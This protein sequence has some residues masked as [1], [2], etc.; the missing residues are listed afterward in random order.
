MGDDYL[1]VFRQLRVSQDKYIYTLLAAAG[2]AVALALN[3]TA[4]DALAIK[5]LP[6]A[7]ALIFWGLSFLCGVRNLQ[8][9][10]SSLYANADFLRVIR[11]EHPSVGNDPVGIQVASAGIRDAME[12]NSSKA[13][14]Y[15]KLQFRFFLIGAASYV[16]WHVLLMYLRRG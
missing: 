14:S 5:H 13:N 4:T 12:S 7:L 2:A 9:V 3:R 16:S 11:G 6:W 8:Y 15:A 10:N 1:E